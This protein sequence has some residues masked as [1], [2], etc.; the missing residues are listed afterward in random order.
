M[1]SWCLETSVTDATEVAGPLTVLL[2]VVCHVC[3]PQV[4]STHL[5][6]HLVF[7]TGQ[8]GAQA[9]SSRKGG[10]AGLTLVRSLRSVHLLDMSIQVIW[11]GETFPTA[12]ADVRFAH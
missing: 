7:M 6:G 8:V 11:P 3:G 1:G 4:L 9:V 10:I 2:Q 5:A 12:L